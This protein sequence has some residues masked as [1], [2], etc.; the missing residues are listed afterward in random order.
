MIKNVMGLKGGIFGLLLKII[1]EFAWSDR[2]T[3]RNPDIIQS[4]AKRALSRPQTGVDVLLIN[5]TDSLHNTVLFFS[6]CC[7]YTPFFSDFWSSLL[8]LFVKFTQDR[9]AKKKKTSRFTVTKDAKITIC[10]SSPIFTSI[11]VN[12]WI[13]TNV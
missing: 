9:R 7:T 12:Y 6:K 2:Q 8:V 13:L 3:C 4:T 10:S 5:V 1:L 11:S